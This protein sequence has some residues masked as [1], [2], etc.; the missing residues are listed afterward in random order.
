[1][2]KNNPFTKAVEWCK[3]HE[4]FFAV[5]LSRL[6]AILFILAGFFFL[7]KSIGIV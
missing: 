5:K 4:E 7:M 1:M 6:L 2:F 3:S